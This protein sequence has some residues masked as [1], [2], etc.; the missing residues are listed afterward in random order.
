MTTD[1]TPQDFAFETTRPVTAEVMARFGV[2]D[3]SA[4][5]YVLDIYCI[6]DDNGDLMDN[7]TRIQVLYHA[8]AG[9]AGVIYGGSDLWTD[10]ASSEDA[11][12][13]YLADEMVN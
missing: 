9:R 5:G 12:R 3:E 7:A 11:V 10:C 6:V 4:R 13:R 8:E 2:E 1:T